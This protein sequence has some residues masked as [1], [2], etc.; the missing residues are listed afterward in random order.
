MMNH[1]MV[2]IPPFVHLFGGRN[3]ARNMNHPTQSWILDTSQKS[4]YRP[5]HMF[6]PVHN[7]SLF[8]EFPMALSGVMS[9][10]V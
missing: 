6:I 9:T 10:I 2:S 5:G 1:C 8:G 4:K 7:W 3:E